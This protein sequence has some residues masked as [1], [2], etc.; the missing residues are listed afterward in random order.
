MA[1]S[2][3]T[4]EL[5]FLQLINNFRSQNG[6]EPL[7]ASQM[8]TEA[9]RRHSQDMA[10][11]NY[12]GHVDSKGLNPKQRIVASGYTYQTKIGENVHASTDGSAKAAFDGWYNACD[13]GT[14]G[15]DPK[16]PGCCT[17]AH[18]VNMLDAGYKVIGIGKATNPNSRYVN[19]WTTDFG[20]YVD[21]PIISSSQQVQQPMTQ[22]ISQQVQQPMTQPIS[23]QVQQ[24]MTQTISQQ[25]QQPMTQTISRQVQQP[26]TVKQPLTPAQKQQQQLINQ[27]INTGQKPGTTPLLNFPNLGGLIPG[28]SGNRVLLEDISGQVNVKVNGED[29]SKIQEEKI[30][31]PEWSKTNKITS[32]ESTKRS[33]G[34]WVIVIILIIIA[35]LVIVFYVK[36]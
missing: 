8:L 27:T 35:I 19:Y 23:Q 5:A 26:M 30:I 34:C 29:K 11:N 10:T 4:D 1:Q 25:V 16:Q 6:V 33:S 28:S 17:Y 13:P 2:L 9:A 18:R 20:G 24:P 22:P 21:S 12:L 14:P 7:Q 36:K 31:S 3:T 32:L 15:C